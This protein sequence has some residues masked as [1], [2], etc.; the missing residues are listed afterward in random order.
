MQ[1]HEKNDL[2]S[3][4]AIVEQVKDKCIDF[5]G[6]LLSWDE[7]DEVTNH[8]WKLEALEAMELKVYVFVCLE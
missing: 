5:Y 6:K 7:T 3:F 8:L 1:W 2:N 4:F